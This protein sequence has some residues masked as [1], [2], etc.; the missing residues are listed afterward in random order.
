[1]GVMQL[2]LD[3]GFDA[4]LELAHRALHRG[5]VTREAIES[6]I[7]QQER[8][9]GSRLLNLLPLTPGQRQRLE[10]PEGGIVP[11]EIV[12]AARDPARRIV[13]YILGENI[14]T[15]GMG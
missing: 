4:D 13:Q 7:L 8:T 10:S 3:P 1:M 14:E 5:W 2:N 9:P 15:G 6:A 12:D 11:D